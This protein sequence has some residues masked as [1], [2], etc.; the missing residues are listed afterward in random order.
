LHLLVLY[1]ILA[2]WVLEIEV[3]GHAGYQLRKAWEVVTKTKSPQVVHTNGLC[4]HHRGARRRGGLAP[5]QDDRKKRITNSALWQRQTRLTEIK[6]VI[7]DTAQQRQQ[8]VRWHWK[9]VTL[10]SASW[11]SCWGRLSPGDV[12]ESR[13]RGFLCRTRQA[14]A[15]E[16]SNQR[17]EREAQ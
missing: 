15:L 7:I 16:Q 12:D 8:R 2:H 6:L 5:Q 11:F 1:I 4:A 10:P 3:S 13:R 9:P 14:Y 17:R